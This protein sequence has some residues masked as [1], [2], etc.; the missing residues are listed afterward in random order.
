MLPR[1]KTMFWQLTTMRQYERASSPAW[2]VLPV[3]PGLAGEKTYD[4]AK[5]FVHFQ[6]VVPKR[7]TMSK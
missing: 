1:L 2:P 6:N 3:L 5:D 7:G 4:N